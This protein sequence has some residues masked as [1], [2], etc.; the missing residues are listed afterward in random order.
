MGLPLSSTRMRPHYR[1]VAVAVWLFPKSINCLIE[2]ISL[3]FA[4][5]S[6]L[7]AP[8]F[9]TQPSSSGSIVSEGR[10]KIIQCHA[11]GE[12]CEN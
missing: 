8:R 6:Q 9:T 10:T 11:L 5:T 1:K 2:K 7:Q 4:E 12:F 3:F